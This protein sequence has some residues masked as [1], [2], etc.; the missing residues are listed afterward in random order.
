M[1]ERQTSQIKKTVSIIGIGRVGLPLA[2]VLAEENFLVYGI[3]NNLEYLKLIKRGIMPFIEEGAESLLVKHLNKN[4]FPT[5]EIANSISQSDYL[6]L[7]LGTPVDENLNPVLNQIK[8][9]LEEIMPYLKK[10]Q[11]LILRSTVSPTTTELI[12]DLIETKRGFKAGKD[13]FI[14][15][16]PERIAEGRSLKEIRSIPQII[17]GVDQISAQKAKEFFLIFTVFTS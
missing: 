8:D 5:Q 16:C 14:A 4:F 13:I 11:V 17:G 1:A 15:F 7:T 6:I 2:L 9:V 10:G 3:D 12:R